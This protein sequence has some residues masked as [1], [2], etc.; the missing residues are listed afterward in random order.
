MAPDVTRSGDDSEPCTLRFASLRPGITASVLWV[1][2]EG[3]EKEYA[4]LEE[5]V[6]DARWRRRARCSVLLPVPL[7]FL[8]PFLNHCPHAPPSILLT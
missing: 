6:R 8:P 4:R 3:E 7:P 2:Y 5:W 1:D